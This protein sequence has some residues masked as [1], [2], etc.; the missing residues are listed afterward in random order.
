[1]VE[2]QRLNCHGGIKISVSTLLGKEEDD[3]EF[4]SL[5]F[6]PVYILEGAP[7][8]LFLMHPLYLRIQT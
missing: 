1:M 6:Y 5:A 3:D 2:A 7:K 8:N 4:E